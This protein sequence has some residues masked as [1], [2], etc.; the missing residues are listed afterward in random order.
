MTEGLVRDDRSFAT[1]S[2]TTSWDTIDRYWL[3]GYLGVWPGM[4][5]L[6]LRGLL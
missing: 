1:M 3:A 6:L 4:K 5:C 2:Y